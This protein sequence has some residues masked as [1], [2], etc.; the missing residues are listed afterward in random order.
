MKSCYQ[1]VAMA[2]LLLLLG[3]SGSDCLVSNG[4]MTAA[5]KACCKKMA[6]QCDMSGSGLHSCCRK[7]VQHH[8]DAELKDSPSAAASPVTLQMAALGSDCFL[9]M[10]VLSFILHEVVTQPPHSPPSP[11]IEILRV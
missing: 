5:E 2:M 8:D 3:V 11:S 6:G 7:V 4:Q 9:E 1:V 10:P